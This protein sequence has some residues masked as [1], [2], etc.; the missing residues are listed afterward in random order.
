MNPLDTHHK[1]YFLLILGLPPDD[2][3]DGNT[4]NEKQH[5]ESQAPRFQSGDG[6][7]AV[8]GQNTQA[9]DEEC[10]RD[11]MFVKNQH[12]TFTQTLSFKVYFDIK[13]FIYLLCQILRFFISVL[14]RN[15]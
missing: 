8:R 10:C 3:H 9:Q 14:E 2:E 13:F 7:D 11:D 1:G 15:P 5:Q 4:E 12:V 6:V